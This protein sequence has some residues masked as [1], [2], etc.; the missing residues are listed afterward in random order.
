MQK[1][2]H[3]TPAAGPCAPVV[4]DL[5]AAD[6]C[7]GNSKVVQTKVWVQGTSYQ[8]S[9]SDRDNLLN[10]LAWLNDNVM[11]AT[12]ALLKKEANATC[13]GSAATLLGPTVRIQCGERRAGANSA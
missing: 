2:Q 11:S 1:L 4:I 13:W 10:P 9:E 6:S 8:L 12:Q 5:T 3:A 7:Q